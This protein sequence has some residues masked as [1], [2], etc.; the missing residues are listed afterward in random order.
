MVIILLRHAKAVQPV[1]D[2]P[3]FDRPLHP[4]GMKQC[5]ALADAI[6]DILKHTG[7]VR[8]A[9]WCSPSLR[10]RQTLINGLPWARAFT[11]LPEAFIQYPKWLYQAAS[12]RLEDELLAYASNVPLMII[13]HNNGLSEWACE[14][15]AGLAAPLGTCHLLVLRKEIHQ[16]PD[17]FE[18]TCRWEPPKFTE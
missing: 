12:H 5:A 2:M 17:P 15:S 18:V 4:K 14:L 1:G 6:P 9:I 16:D 7:G 13:G 10:T 8:P 11:T 3:D